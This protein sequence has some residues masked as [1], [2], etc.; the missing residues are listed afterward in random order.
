MRA[1]TKLVFLT[2]QDNKFFGEGPCRLLRM[3]E[4]TGSLNAAAAAMDMAYTKALRLLK[5][6]EAALGF[7]LTTRAIGGRNGG[8]SRL[9]DAGRVWLEHYEAY[10]DNCARVNQELYRKYFP[11]VGCVIMASGMGRRFGG[12]KLM[13]DFGGEP[14]ICRALKATDGLFDRRV[15]VTRHEDVAVLCRERGVEVVFHDLPLRSDTV[16]LGLEALGD[17]DGCVFCPGDQP[18]LRRETVAA[19]LCSWRGENTA[20]WR[21]A[22][23][24]APGSPV[25]FPA[26]TFDDLLNLPE[27]KG[28][29]HVLGRYPD[30]VRCMQV[31][32]EY[33]LMD[34]DTPEALDA[35]RARMPG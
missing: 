16:R 14:M 8:G 3:V 4:E 13:A 1:Q 34:A 27:G 33:E 20:I 10:R 32:D 17:V 29:G 23:G 5:N 25:L 11:P 35:L 31:S 24:D 26:W 2:D 12:N 6:A 30:R 28:G 15:V 7:P 18:L 9:T 22:F 19:L 21:A